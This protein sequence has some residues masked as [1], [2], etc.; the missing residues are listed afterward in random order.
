MTGRSLNQMVRSVHAEHGLED[1]FLHRA[2]Y[3]VGIN[4][5]DLA[6]PQWHP[7]EERSVE[8]G[9]TFHLVP[10]LMDPELG[11]VCLSQP[12]LVT[13]QGAEKLLDYP[14]VSKPL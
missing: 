3:S 2:G 4:W 7:G 14:L 10:H 11:L 8:A 5:P 9:M 6:L 12:L 1:M 13:D